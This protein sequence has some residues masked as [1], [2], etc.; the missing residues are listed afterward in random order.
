VV[1]SPNNATQAK[2]RSVLVTGVVLGVGVIGA[3]DEAIFHQVLQWHTLY[4]SSSESVR[5][6]SDGIF[7]L[8]T[9]GLLIAG[10]VRLWLTSATLRGRRDVL[11]AAML[12]GAGGFNLYDG[13]V[14][15]VILHLHLVNEHVCSDPS[16]NNSLASCPADLPYELVWLLFATS[17]LLVGL[18]R[19][20]AACAKTTLRSEK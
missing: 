6:L 18:A 17:L 15:H 13:L 14:Q 5:L 8:I 1:T 10:G 3:L 4:W 16:V 11:I 20:Q 7:H 2:D 19:W 12:I 9:L